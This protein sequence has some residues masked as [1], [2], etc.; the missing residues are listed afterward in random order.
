MVSLDKPLF[1]FIIKAAEIYKY[2]NSDVSCEETNI[3]TEGDTTTVY[4]E[5]H[6][7]YVFTEHTDIIQNDTYQDVVEALVEE[8][9]YYCY[10]D[11]F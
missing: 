5:V 10:N 11:S 4:Y 9:G 6:T 7:Y 3:I 8:I 1:L 2:V